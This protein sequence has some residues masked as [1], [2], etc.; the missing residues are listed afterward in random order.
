MDFVKIIS[1]IAST[2]NGGLYGIITGLTIIVFVLITILG[3]VVLAMIKNLNEKAKH[4]EQTKE[5][6][7]LALETIAKGNDK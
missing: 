3:K 4:D 1:E 2:N 5:L 6:L 7:K